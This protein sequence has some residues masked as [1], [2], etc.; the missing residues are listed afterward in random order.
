MKFE[1]HDTKSGN[2]RNSRDTI[3]NQ[4]IRFM[5]PEFRLFPQNSSSFSINTGNVIRVQS[6]E[7]FFT[8]AIYS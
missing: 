8:L 2:Q 7:T 3:P 6:S 4:E 5:S 1:G